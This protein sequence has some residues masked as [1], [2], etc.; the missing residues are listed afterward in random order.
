MRG[1][2][3]NLEYWEDHKMAQVKAGLAHGTI[4]YPF[5]NTRC[6][7]Y[8]AQGC[9]KQ[10]L[11]FSAAG[12]YYLSQEKGDLVDFDI[13]DDLIQKIQ[14]DQ[15]PLLSCIAM[16]KAGRSSIDIIRKGADKAAALKNFIETTSRH[17]S[18]VFYFGDE[19]FEGGNDQP[20]ADS[21]ELKK[22]GLCILALNKEI[23]P[24]Q[25]HILWMGRSY[26]ATGQFLAS[27]P[28]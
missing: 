24:K 18:L 4:S 17:G 8:D 27:L 15:D 1:E 21:A 6:V 25:T 28:I 5:I 9:I 20:I 2:P 10:L 16:R 14:A 11:G 7:Q 22:L 3:W 13:R 23:P 12:F 19:F 26:D